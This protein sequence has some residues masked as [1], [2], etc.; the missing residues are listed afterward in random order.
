M[1]QCALRHS[2]VQVSPGHDGRRSQCLKKRDFV[3][4]QNCSINVIDYNEGDLQRG[5]DTDPNRMR[6]FHA[7][8]PPC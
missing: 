2:A 4:H 5:A 7:T 8:G 3:G 6:R 1:N